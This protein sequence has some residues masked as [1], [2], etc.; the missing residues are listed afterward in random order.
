MSE[1]KDYIDQ[2]FAHNEFSETFSIALS[3]KATSKKD[4]L[5]WFSMIEPA[6]GKKNSGLTRSDINKLGV[7]YTTLNNKRSQDL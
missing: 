5:S 3:D 1:I 7:I 2:N 6:N 4:K